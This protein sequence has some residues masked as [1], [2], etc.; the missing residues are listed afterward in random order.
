M[1]R[2]GPCRKYQP[3]NRLFYSGEGELM[4]QVTEN[5]FVETGYRGC[6]PGFIVTSDGLVQIDSPHRPTDGIEYKKALEKYGIVKYFINTEPHGDHFSS[7]FLFEATFVAHQDTRTRMT[8]KAFMDRMKQML[9]MVDPDYAPHLDDYSVPL[10]EITFT[11][12]MALF[13]GEHTLKLLHLPGHTASQTAV[14]IPEERV[15]FTGDNIFHKSPTFMHEALPGRWLD[16]LEKLKDLDVEYYIPGHGD[17]CGRDY[18]GEQASVVKEWIEV[19]RNAVNSGWSIEEAQER[20]SFLDRYT[21]EEE[22]KERVREMEK[23]GIANVYELV[24]TGQL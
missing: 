4:E 17:V 11:D 3:E 5:V 18:L 13:V 7:N 16:S 6:N 12:S 19:A 2:F 9:G 20:I 15:V 10:P 21:V 23:V 8:D 24:K 22:M 14:F 1:I